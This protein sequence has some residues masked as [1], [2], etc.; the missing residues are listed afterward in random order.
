MYVCV[1]VCVPELARVCEDNLKRSLTHG[2]RRHVPSH[3]ELDALLV[4]HTH[5]LALYTCLCFIDTTVHVC[6]C[7][8]L[9]A[10]RSTRRFPLQ[11]PG[12]VEFPC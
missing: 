11:F 2:G 6:V 10:G 7:V 5:T 9:Q 8:F 1:C 4:T 12:G 3:L